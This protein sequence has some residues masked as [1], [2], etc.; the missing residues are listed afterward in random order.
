MGEGLACDGG[1]GMVMIC[2][3]CRSICYAY[4]RHVFS[5]YKSFLQRER[6]KEREGGREVFRSVFFGHWYIV[7]VT[8]TVNSTCQIGVVNLFLLFQRW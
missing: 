7:K 5:L 3:T 2:C 1:G 4:A 8:Q 6:E